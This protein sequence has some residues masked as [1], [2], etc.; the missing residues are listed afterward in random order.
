MTTQEKL[1]TIKQ[2]LDKLG[3]SVKEKM[4]TVL[5]SQKHLKH[6]VDYYKKEDRF[7]FVN[8]INISFAVMNYIIV[9]TYFIEIPKEGDINAIQ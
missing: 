5:F 1:E 6:T 3:W 7:V 8:T 2:E 9:Y 4:T